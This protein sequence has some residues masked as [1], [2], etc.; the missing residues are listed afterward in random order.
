LAVV[1]KDMSEKSHDA[2]QWMRK[3]ARVE[4]FFLNGGGE[5]RREEK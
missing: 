1:S 5:E 4:E 2:V 3:P